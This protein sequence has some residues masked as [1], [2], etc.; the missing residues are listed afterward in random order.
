VIAWTITAK[1]APHHPGVQRLKEPVAC[2]GLVTSKY[3]FKRHREGQLRGCAR[4]ARW[5]F[6]PLPQGIWGWGKEMDVCWSHLLYQGILANPDEER[7]TEN[8]LKKHRAGK[9]RQA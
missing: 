4:S 7:R 2:Q 3:S 6:K 9:G 1:E 8:F 5:H